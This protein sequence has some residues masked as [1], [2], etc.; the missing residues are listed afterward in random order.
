M[1]YNL[2]DDIEHLR[3]LF[4][5]IGGLKDNSPHLALV[6]SRKAAESICKSIWVQETG[7]PFQGKSMLDGMIAKLEK[8][9]YMPKKIAVSIRTIQH[10]GNIGS[11]DHSDDKTVLTSLDITPCLQALGNVTKWYCEKYGFEQ[12]FALSDIEGLVATLAKSNLDKRTKLDRLSLGLSLDADDDVV[13]FSH[14]YDA[15]KRIDILDTEAGKYTSHRWLN[16]TNTSNA[17]TYGVPHM[18]AGENK[19]R[20]ESLKVKAFLNSRDGERL[21]VSSRTD[22]QP[23]FS[24]KFFI[25]FP[26]PLM[27]GESFQLYYRLSW[28]G[29][30]LAYSGDE[31]S[32]SISF[33][34]YPK[35]VNKL[36]FGMLDKLAV[37]GVRSTKILNDFEEVDVELKP[38]F[39]SAEDEADLNPVHDKGLKGFLYTFEKVDAVSYRLFY[40]LNF[41]IEEDDDDEF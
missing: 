6:Q 18:E 24:Q 3:E 27:P 2:S 14:C 33:A 10:F 12:T 16:L 13:D 34:R 5:D 38:H 4:R 26:E 25:H 11:H 29:E 15:L 28:P 1:G 9:N 39:F 41:K 20:F 36:V 19:V 21:A 17:A 37:S 22:V 30:T 35:G 40:R 7:E 32:Q 31:H 23:N 8:A